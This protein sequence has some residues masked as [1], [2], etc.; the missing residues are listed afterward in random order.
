[1][2][3][4]DSNVKIDAS[5]VQRNDPC[6]DKMR[7]GSRLQPKLTLVRNEPANDN[8]AE[9]GPLRARLYVVLCSC[10]GLWLLATLITYIFAR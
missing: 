6:N 4:S 3:L 1:M 7:V 10:L 2:R 8:I 5:S 9:R